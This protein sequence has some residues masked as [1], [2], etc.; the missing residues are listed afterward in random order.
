MAGL[1][2]HMSILTLTL[3]LNSTLIVG[4]MRITGDRLVVVGSRCHL[5]SMEH[6]LAFSTPDR[7]LRTVF[8]NE[9]R[10]LTT[11]ITLT[12][13]TPSSTMFYF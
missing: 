4:H 2:G 8:V 10:P 11:L 1:V 12:L 5:I 3:T 9:D 6:Y 7:S 13:T